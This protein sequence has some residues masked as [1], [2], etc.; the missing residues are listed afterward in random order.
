MITSA[1]G[2]NNALQAFQTTPLQPQGAD[3]LSA[4]EGFEGM[5]KGLGA[6]VF[7]SLRAGES[8]AIAAIEGKVS[9]QQAV[10]ATMEAEKSLQAALAI[11]DKIV[12]A[13]LEISRMQ[14]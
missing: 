4:G 5:L 11:R 14:I 13:F 1:I 8:T 3:K 12:S 2:S 10:M 6:N 7:E 9:A